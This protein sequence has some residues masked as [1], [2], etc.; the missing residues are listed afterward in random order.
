MMAA[1]E[2]KS[3][4]IFNNLEVSNNNKTN[5]NNLKNIVNDVLLSKIQEG[6]FNSSIDSTRI[7]NK[8][9][10]IYMKTGSLINVNEIK[11]NINDQLSLKLREDF[12]SQ[13]KYFDPTELSS[14]IRK[15]IVLMNNNGFPFA[16]FEF[17]N[18]EIIDSKINLEC[19]LI[20]GPLVRIDS[21]INPE[22]STKELMLVSKIINIKNGDVFNLSE[23][24]KISENIRKS[25][26]LKEIKPP[27]YEF[28]D[29]FASIYTY[30]KTESKNSVNGLIGIQPSENDK[31]QFTGN[32]S[33]NFLNAL[34]F[35]ETLKLNWRKMFNS[36]QNLIS[37][38]SI[39][40]IFKTNIE[41]MG[42]LDMIKKDS[43]FF[44][45]NSKFIVKYRLNSNLTSG[46]LF[47][48]NNST[49]LLQSNY[50]S[51]TV[52]SFGFTA[53]L[54]KT[55]NKYNPS[56]GYLFKTELSYGWKQTFSNDTSSSNILRTPNFNGKLEIDTYWDI[57][58]RTTLKMKLT[59][60][61]IQN[62]I[63]YE[64]E[65]IRIGGYRTIRGFNEE[66]IMVSSFILSNL[67]F[68]YLLDEKSNVFIFSD[69]AWTESKTNEFLKEEYYQ[70]FGFGTNI[71]MKNGLFTFI[72]G[73]G[74]KIDNPFLIRIGKIHF[75]F[76]S[77]F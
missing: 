18:Y 67:E 73:I 7:I 24:Y 6:Y 3:Y 71:S 43:S 13:K 51:T 35:G 26:F 59:G 31:I 61:T 1:Q 53:D 8:N 56:K 11:V 16:E 52:N 15:W 46:F 14:K 33:L 68:R 4:R 30:V 41:I 63:L 28:V 76:T 32:V 5:S 50:S 38:F 69:F 27:A 2:I 65:L 25:V 22:I 74:R 57:I 45:L 58:R 48:K 19:N 66:S 49:N 17:K 64:N 77:Y 34:N 40:F 72:Y 10:E 20:S 62:D 37:E 36:S 39:P 70:S 29:N 12:V 9:L 42:G 21:L 47:A 23:I 75:G 60:S 55:N 44:N 54:K